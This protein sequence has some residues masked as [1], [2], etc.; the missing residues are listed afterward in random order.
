MKH[1]TSSGERPPSF[2][3]LSKTTRAA[4]GTAAGVTALVCGAFVFGPFSDAR[5]LAM[6]GVRDAGS[7]G[8]AKAG[9][10]V[11]MAGVAAAVHRLA[12]AAVPAARVAKSAPPSEGVRIA[13]AEAP[14]DESS[15]LTAPSADVPTMP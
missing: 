5:A 12:R 6:S 15:A 11:E 13:S 8:Y 14:A 10:A 4:L 3:L 1:D 9:E 2:R 7:S